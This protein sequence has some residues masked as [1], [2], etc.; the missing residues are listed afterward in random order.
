MLAI[1]GGR[2]RRRH[3]ARDDAGGELVFVHAVPTPGRIGSLTLVIHGPVP[4]VT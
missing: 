4:E 3:R 2:R 1:V